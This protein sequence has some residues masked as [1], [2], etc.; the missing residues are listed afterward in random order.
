MRRCQRRGAL[1]AEAC[2]RTRVL[3]GLLGFFMT[4]V[5]FALTVVQST[6]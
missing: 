3:A 1:A 5:A 6:T 4:L 2:A